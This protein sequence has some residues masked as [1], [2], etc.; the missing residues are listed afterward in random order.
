MPRMA[1]A[2]LAG[3]PHHLTQRGVNRQTVFLTDGD[4]RIYLELV[5]ESAQRFSVELLGYCLMTN[6]VHWI[7]VPGQ[8]DSLAKAFAQAHGRYAHY[9]NAVL[10]RSGHFW[11]NRFFSC[12]LEPAHLWAALRY[13]ERNPVRA[14]LVEIADQW[15]WSSASVHTG[16]MDK[17]DWLDVT[18]WSH[19]FTQMDW[20]SFLGAT[21]LADSERLLRIHTY[22]GR[23]L[24]SQA[25]VESAELKLG[26]RL[27]KSKGGR[28]AKANRSLP[29]NEPAEEAIPALDT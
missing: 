11:Q 19:R 6:H 16:R 28:P 27:Q 17:P 3:V 29:I 20:L 7:V 10:H 8:S 4:R 15:P 14:G 25:F 21:Q 26:R 18:G 23:P 24:G 1:R 12:A 9:A 22:A 13:V 2:V 5:L